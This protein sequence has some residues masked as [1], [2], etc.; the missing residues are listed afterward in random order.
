MRVLLGLAG[1]LGFGVLLELAPRLGLVP[2]RYAPPTSEILGTLAEQLG[3][4]DFWV[5]VLDTLRTWLLGLVIAVA[6]GVVVGVV[7]GSIP[8]LRAATASTIEFLRP[9]PSVALIPLVVVVAGPTITATLYLVVYAAFWQVLL[10]VL[11]G[12]ADIDPVASDTARTYH[13]DRWTRIRYLVWPTALPYVVT[14]VRL[15][16]TVALILTITGELVIGSPGLGQEIATARSSG[17]VS[18]M[19]ALIVVTGLFG[20]AANVL[21]RAAQRRALAWHPSIRTEVPA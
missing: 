13:L 7:I 14:G 3:R 19:Y 21:T 16:A 17:A 11:A 12:V 2:A 4:G 8:V 18:D 10:Q 6:L 15:A 20:V 5:A 1:L 9:I